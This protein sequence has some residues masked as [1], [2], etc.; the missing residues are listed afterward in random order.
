MGIKIVK[1]DQLWCPAFFCDICK[2]KI[3]DAERGIV[4]YN[5]KPTKP[6]FV[7]K[8]TCDRKFR[9]ELNAKYSCWMQLDDFLVY[10]INNT[11]SSPKK[12]AERLKRLKLFR[13]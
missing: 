3:E 1:Q 12:L 9:D 10:I 8:F 13:I 11:G 4:L 7:H 6:F 5:F 2:E